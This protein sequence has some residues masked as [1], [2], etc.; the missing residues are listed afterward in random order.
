MVRTNPIAWQN[1]RDFYQ[2]S[3]YNLL[4][5]SSPYFPS[6]EWLVER[7]MV[8]EIDYRGFRIEVVACKARGAWDAEI[9]IRRAL[10]AAMACAGRLASRALTAR[11]AE[12]RGVASARHWVDRHARAS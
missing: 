12:E 4:V 10:S 8:A 11:V 1:G 5:R 2:F 6:A 3:D 9:R 7:A